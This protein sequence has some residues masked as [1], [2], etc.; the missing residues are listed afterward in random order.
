[1]GSPEVRPEEEG[2]VAGTQLPCDTDGLFG[3]EVFDT[4]FY[5]T[6]VKCVHLLRL[7]SRVRADIPFRHFWLESVFL[8][9]D[10][11]VVGF[12]QGGGAELQ[13]GDDPGSGESVAQEVLAYEPEIARCTLLVDVPLSGVARRVSGFVQVVVDATHALVQAFTVFSD[14]VLVRVEAGVE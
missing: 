12:V 6:V 4:A 3:H 10:F 14:A 2:L 11:I 8:E 1:M 5:R 7:A 13:S 9:V